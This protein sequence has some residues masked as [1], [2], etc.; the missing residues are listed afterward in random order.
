[1]YGERERPEKFVRKLIH[2]M[3]ADQ[4]IPL[5][6][7]SRDHIRSY[8]YVGDAVKGILAPLDNPA[9]A[10]G[11]IFNIG[12]DVTTTTGKVIDIVE[13]IL[14]KEAR[15]RNAPR[16]PGDQKETAACIAKARTLLGYSPTTTIEDGLARQVDW[17]KKNESKLNLL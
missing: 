8:T 11:Q 10:I 7:G 13:S 5:Y 14:G 16:R 15:I 17:M 1:V 3:L 2:S 6:E 12:T 4:E 9:P